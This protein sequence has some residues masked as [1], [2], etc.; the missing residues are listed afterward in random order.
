M[1]IVQ[2]RVV[3]VLTLRWTDINALVLRQIR[4]P[5]ADGLNDVV[6]GD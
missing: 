3:T 4:F 2:G 6:L 1:G 5:P